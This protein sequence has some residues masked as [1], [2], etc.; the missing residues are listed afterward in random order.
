MSFVKL[1][2]EEVND[3][4]NGYDEDDKKQKMNMK[5]NDV[6]Q[7]IEANVSS[8]LGVDPGTF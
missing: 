4:D 1:I 5:R 3:S 2:N 7:E 8:F 6:A